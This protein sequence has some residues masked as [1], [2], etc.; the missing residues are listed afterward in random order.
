VAVAA[1]NDLTLEEISPQLIQVGPWEPWIVMLVTAVIFLLIT[2]AISRNI[3]GLLF[4]GDDNRY[5]NSK[6]QLSLWF[7]VVI[8][9]YV[10]VFYMRWVHAGMIGHIGIPTNLL[11]LSGLSA[12]T[13]AGAKGITSQKNA[14]AQQQGQPGK[15]TGNPSFPGDL[16]RSDIVGQF[17]LGDFQMIVITLIAVVSYVWIASNF[18]GNLAQCHSATLPDVDGTVLALFG[19]GQGAYLTKKAATDV[20]H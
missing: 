1:N 10:S 11:V 14:T 16:I 19:V 5:S 2:Y 9:T 12:L 18:L 17:D 15:T 3:R 8:V 20:N 4:I 6:T 7:G 13:F